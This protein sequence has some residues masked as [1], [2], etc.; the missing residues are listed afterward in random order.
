MMAR[1]WFQ[2]VDSWK[3]KLIRVQQCELRL[4]EMERIETRLPRELWQGIGGVSS[5]KAVADKSGKR[6][7]C[8]VEQ[9]SIETRWAKQKT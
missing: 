3:S 9:E 2:L 8:N 7:K 4:I 5:G 1:N 6:L